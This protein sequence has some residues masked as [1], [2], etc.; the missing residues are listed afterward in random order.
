MPTEMA[1]RPSRLG[2]RS[3]VP[4]LDAKVHSPP[5]RPGPNGYAMR[6]VRAAA[7]TSA[8]GPNFVRVKRFFKFR[9]GRS[10]R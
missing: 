7:R 4:I 2:S 10:I 5:Y 9:Q 1:L 6:S 8:G 3:A